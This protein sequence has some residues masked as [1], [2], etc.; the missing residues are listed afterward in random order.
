MNPT[1]PFHQVKLK[2]SFYTWSG[3]SNIQ[4]NAR[5][6]TH[7]RSVESILSGSEIPII[8][9]VSNNEIVFWQTHV[10]DGW[11][12]GRFSILHRYWDLACCQQHKGSRNLAQRATWFSFIACQCKWSLWRAPLSCRCYFRRSGHC[13]GLDI[14]ARWPWGSLHAWPVYL[15]LSPH[16]QSTNCLQFMFSG[17]DKTSYYQ[18]WHLNILWEFSMWIALARPHTASFLAAWHP[19]SLVTQMWYCI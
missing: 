4:S 7:I 9:D 16:H 10:Q 15:L 1:D 19:R 11:S 3:L 5:P 18:G 14:V 2:L 8:S 13:P 17:L 6:C 12:N